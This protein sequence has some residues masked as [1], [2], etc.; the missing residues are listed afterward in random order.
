MIV[1]A[2]KNQR[3]DPRENNESAGAASAFELVNFESVLLAGL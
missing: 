3:R 2:I 1:W